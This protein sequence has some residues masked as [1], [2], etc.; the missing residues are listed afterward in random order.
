MQLVQSNVP[1]DRLLPAE[2]TGR[3]SRRGRPSWPGATWQR[4]TA[5]GNEQAL[6]LLEPNRTVIV[7]GDARDDGAARTGRR[8]ALTGSTRSAGR[9]CPTRRQGTEGI[10]PGALLGP[11]AR[12]SRRRCRAPDPTPPGDR[13]TL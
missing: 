2:L 12:R 8:A 4:Y 7:V 1:A 6:V 3:A 13:V 9:D 10:D 11:V 5:R